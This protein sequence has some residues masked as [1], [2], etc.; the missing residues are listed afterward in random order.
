M[1]LKKYFAIIISII[2]GL[3]ILV[4]S[5]IISQTFMQNEKTNDAK[6]YISNKYSVE[7]TQ[8]LEINYTKKHMELDS[9]LFERF[10]VWVVPDRW[11][12]NV[13]GKEFNVEYIDDHF[14]DDYQLEDLE[15]WCTEYLQKNINCDISGIE[16]YSDMIFHDNTH[17][18]FSKSSRYYTVSS[19][20]PLS[21]S[22]NKLWKREEISEFL[23]YQFEN[24]SKIGV[25]LKV[26][27]IS[28]YS[29]TG[30]NSEYEN[31]VLQL[32]SNFNSKNCT[33][34]PI[35]YSSII[36]LERTG[37]CQYLLYNRYGT[38]ISCQETDVVVH[39]F[40]LKRR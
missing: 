27:D 12:F 31:L 19:S 28:K 3:L 39:D 33:L 13:N 34:I 10:Y 9:T 40:T 16:L 38:S 22:D 1:K 6:R 29:E 37:K 25:F 11:I 26:N 2:F 15:I 5:I 35:L 4:L 24:Y 18:L 32:N 8:I 23:K 36:Q 14:V 20:K 7:E 30:I 17:D 21:Y